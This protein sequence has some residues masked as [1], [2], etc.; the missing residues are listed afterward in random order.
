[1]AFS[2]E[3]A[4]KRGLQDELTP[5]YQ[6]AGAHLAVMRSMTADFREP[7]V[8]LIICAVAGGV[9]HIVL[10]IL[11]DQDLVKHDQAEVGVEYEL[12]AIFER[13]GHSLPP[14]DTTRVKG[15]HNYVGRIIASHF[16]LGIYAIW[17]QYNIMVEPNAHFQTNWVQEDALSAAVQSMRQPS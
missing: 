10:F 12:S 8:W 7:W 15:Q 2:W 5:A 1:M 6:R 11:L 4:G 14:P 17:W 13:L 16:S 3:E 9:G